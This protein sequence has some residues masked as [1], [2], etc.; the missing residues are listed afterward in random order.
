MGR[1]RP[2]VRGGNQVTP[3]LFL[4]Y[5]FEHRAWWAP[6]RNGYVDRRIA[7]GRYTFEE[8]VSIC[9]QANRHGRVINRPEEAMVPDED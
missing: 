1:Q 8:A 5:S 4:I 7:A 3:Q 9:K 2:T 6:D